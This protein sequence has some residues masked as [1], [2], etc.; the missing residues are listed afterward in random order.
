MS[1]H[2]KA[3]ADMEAAQQRANEAAAEWKKRREAGGDADELLGPILLLAYAL[4]EIDA[5]RD[6][7]PAA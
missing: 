1:D 4:K 7:L 3:L 5:A 2:A 6:S